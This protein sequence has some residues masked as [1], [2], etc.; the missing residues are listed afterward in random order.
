MSSE[1]ADELEGGTVKVNDWQRVKNNKRRKI[2][3]S[4]VNIPE[5]QRLCI[6]SQRA[7]VASYD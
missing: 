3:T 2:N 6:S 4:Q 1:S 5:I 7:S